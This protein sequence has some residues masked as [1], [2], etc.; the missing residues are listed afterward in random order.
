MPGSLQSALQPAAPTNSV[1]GEDSEGG[2]VPITAPQAGLAGDVN[3]DDP[4]VDRSG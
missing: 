3:A 4:E 2:D 1:G